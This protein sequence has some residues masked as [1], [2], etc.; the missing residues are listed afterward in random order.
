MRLGIDFALEDLLG[1]RNREVGN[2]VAQGIARLSG[3]L[4]HFGVTAGDD[5]LLLGGCVAL[6]LLDQLR[7]LL[8]GGGDDVLRLGPRGLQLF[9]GLRR[10]FGKGCLALFSGRQT[11]AVSWCRIS[12]CQKRLDRL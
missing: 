6:G 9:I 4:L 3:H 10:R 11:I 12:R 7:R 8:V 5:P 2:L 1:A